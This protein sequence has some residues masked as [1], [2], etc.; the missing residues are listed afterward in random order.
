[1]RASLLAMFVAAASI[2]A[3][4]AV[5]ASTAP[6]PSADDGSWFASGG[7]TRIEFNPDALRRFDLA[8]ERVDG[9]LDRVEGEPGLRYDASEFAALAASDL[10]FNHHGAA[11]S[12]IGGGALRHAGGLVLRHRGESFDL[13]GF[14]LHASADT[15]LGL[16]LVDA[17]GR[18][19]FT[20]DHAHYGFEGDARD[21]FAMRHMNL[22]LA[23]RLA[24]LLGARPGTVVGGLDLHASTSAV[25][26]PAP[27]GGVC[28]APWPG[29][30][31]PAG[32]SMIYGATT[33]TGW[34]DSV[35]VKRDSGDCTPSS[36]TCHIVVNADSTLRNSG[37][38]AV[39][40]YEK[41]N[42]NQPGAEGVPQPP[43]AN[44][45]HPYLI[46]NLYRVDSAGRIR[47]IGASG[48]KHAFYTVN[49]A[50]TDP[51]CG[52]GHVIYPQC[53]DTYSNYN[54]DGSTYLGP[55][56]E[57]VPHTAIWGRCGSVYDA[58]CDGV[59]DD[60][61]GAQ[62]LFQYRMLVDESDLL[63]PKA[64]GARYYL[65]YW[66]VVRDDDA[67]YDSMAY[68][69]VAFTKSD[70]GTTPPSA[71]WDVDLVGDVPAGADYHDG[72]ALNH[73]VSPAVALVNAVNTELATP[74]GRVRVAVRVR[75]AGSGHWR[76][77]FA[78]ANFDY[79]HAQV[80][81][82][83]PSEPNLQL[84]ANHGFVRFSVP[85][86]AGTTVSDTRFDD[87]DLDGG[88]DWSVATTT[89]AVTWSAPSGANSLDWGTLYH[90]EF[91]STAPPADMDLGLVGTAT[92][93]EGE[94][95]YV[96][97]IRFGDTIFVDGY[98]WIE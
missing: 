58:D 52:P 68:R 49:F 2:A 25:P 70:L 71:A 85:L 98:D 82:A 31:N 69:E 65:E 28:N 8:I 59:N 16:D 89:N 12:G 46:W 90:F 79:A 32:I 45:Q 10:Q 9:A 81:P 47:Q 35:Y 67:I 78:L 51:G 95:P 87:A 7:R 75:A 4:P 92:T 88:N 6:A 94:L 15:R 37:A 14:A 23:P 60:G 44:D 91:V 17:Q 77:E 36:T 11:L 19:W 74:L 13:R 83:H 30:G 21:V 34:S 27:A 26:A 80:D 40:W 39:A 56:S 84:D 73:W 57:I 97:P 72:P 38:T 93:S 86:A 55:R 62:D 24:A 50:C 53:E 61:S 33:W 18:A 43:Y 54:N 29:P 1:M 96:V 76:Y 42:R 20:A 66:Y 5:A 64:T 48:V 3:A 22:R 63:P 41:F